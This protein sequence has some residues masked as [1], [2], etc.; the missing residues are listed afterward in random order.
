MARRRRRRR[1]IDPRYAVELVLGRRQTGMKL[2]KNT[3]SWISYRIFADGEEIGTVEIG[4]GSIFWKP[5][6]N[7]RYG[8]S[9]RRSWRA[10]AERMERREA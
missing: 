9:Y 1:H 2:P 8:H 7:K 4:R 3:G 5:Y 10:F 6:R